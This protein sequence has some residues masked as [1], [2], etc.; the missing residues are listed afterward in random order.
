MLFGSDPPT[1]IVT[2]TRLK[3]VA[4]AAGAAPQ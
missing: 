4:A 1:R 3:K 2:V